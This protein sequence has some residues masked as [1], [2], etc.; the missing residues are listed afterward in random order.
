MVSTNL[1]SLL[2]EIEG[3]F[4]LHDIYRNLLLSLA[5]PSPVCSSIRPKKEVQLILKAINEGAK[6]KENPKLMRS[7]HQ[8][9]PIIFEICE[10]SAL[11]ENVKNLLPELW[12]IAVQSFVDAIQRTAAIKRML[13]TLM[14]WVIFQVL[15]SIVI[16]DVLKRTN[17]WDRKIRSNMIFVKRNILDIQVYYQEFS[18]CFVPMVSFYGK[19]L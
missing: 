10:K 12:T 9:I 2:L 3:D 11:C 13:F 17:I 4:S 6:I 1:Y 18:H 8:E 5:S 19:F 16:E 7:L 14:S 15:K